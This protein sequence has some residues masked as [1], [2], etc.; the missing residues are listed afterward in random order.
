MAKSAAVDTR[1]RDAELAE[2]NRKTK[3]LLADFQAATDA[4]EQNDRE[5]QRLMD[6]YGVKGVAGGVPAKLDKL[7]EAQRRVIE[8]FQLGLERLQAETRQSAAA[9]AKKPKGMRRRNMV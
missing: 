8:S 2:L 3:K 5:V 1:K 4:K 6:E 9:P 7:P